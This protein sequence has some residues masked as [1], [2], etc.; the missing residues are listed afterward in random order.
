[1]MKRIEAS[2]LDEYLSVLLI[3]PASY[4][5]RRREMIL[6]LAI[7]SQPSSLFFFSMYM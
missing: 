4:E 2:P 3:P 5:E 1:M 7:R 6:C